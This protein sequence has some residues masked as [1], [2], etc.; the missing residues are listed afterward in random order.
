MDWTKLHEVSEVVK[1]FAEALA[2]FGGVFALLKW[3][4]ERHDRSTDVLLELT[5]QFDQQECIQGR[6]LIDDD[7]AYGKIVSRLHTAVLEASEP[8]PLKES[9][10]SAE[11]N[12]EL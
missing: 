4:S 1:N 5:T 9:A 11:D 3:L 6:T 12:A 2:I 8:I 7:V 10:L